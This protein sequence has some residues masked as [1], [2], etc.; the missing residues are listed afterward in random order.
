[1][2]NRSNA[3][4]RAK[5]SI[6]I[7]IA[8]RIMTDRKPGSW[9]A[10]L[11]VI[12]IVFCPIFPSLAYLFPQHGALPCYCC[13]NVDSSCSLRCACGC[14]HPGSDDQVLEWEAVPVSCRQLSFLPPSL[15]LSD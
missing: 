4:C 14:S 11:L 6:S 3:D 15:A 13:M 5:M 7:G 10:V 12:S 2:E 8:Q 9:M 1:M